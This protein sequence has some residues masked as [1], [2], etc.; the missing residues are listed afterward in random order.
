MEN[1]TL[2]AITTGV[3]IGAL[4]L[5]ATLDRKDSIVDISTSVSKPH[6]VA[7]FIDTN[8]NGQFDSY[9]IFEKID[10]KKRYIHWEEYSTYRYTRS[11]YFH[12]PFGGEESG[13]F[14]EE[15]LR[16]IFNNLHYPEVDEIRFMRMNGGTIQNDIT[17][18]IRR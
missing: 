11:I 14:D 13:E 8:K 15:S 9:K 5:V 6:L 4:G 2:L 12:T 16:S 3:V 7:E 18:K 1:K 10:G 17:D